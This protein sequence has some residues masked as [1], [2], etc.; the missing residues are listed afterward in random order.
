MIFKS[1]LFSLWFGLAL[2]A[3][4][5]LFSAF[6]SI[7]FFMGHWYYPAVM[8][9]GAFVAGLTPQ[10]GGAVAFPAL[11]V[12]LHIDRVLAR[13]FSMMIQSIGMT[14][15]SI[16]ILTHK[17]TVL[18][19]YKPLLIFVPVC[20]AG[21]LLGMLTLQ[22][23]PVYL[24]QALFVSLTAT[25]VVAYY[26]HEH[27]GTEHRLVVPRAWDAAYLG[28]TLFLGGM[29]TSLFGTGADILLYTLLITHFGMKEKSATYVSIVLQAAVSILGFTYRGF[30]DHGLSHYQIETW[31]CAYPVA[32]F[33][34][35]FGAY[36]LSRLHVDWM[37]IAIVVLNIFQLLYFNLSRPAYEKTLASGVFCLFFS[38]AFYLLLRHMS[39]RKARLAASPRCAPLPDEDG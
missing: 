34:A 10:G 27:R 5:A 15:A 23:M 11:S 39:A 25:F 6:D 8:V 9:L 28:I 30:V 38:A 14:S 32:L 19:D 20:F 16:F 3:W 17:D 22:A 24:I 4:I 31:L 21:F 2:L 35:P 37:L 26:F 7:G 18:K 36:V 13:D 1:K 33:M 29:I 12:F